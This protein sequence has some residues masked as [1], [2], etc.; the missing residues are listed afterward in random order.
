MANINLYNLYQKSSVW[1]FA[2]SHT[3]T[4]ELI[5]AVAT[6]QPGA[7]VT[8]P[9]TAKVIVQLPLRHGLYLNSTILV[10][11]TNPQPVFD[12]AVRGCHNVWYGRRIRIVVYKM[13]KKSLRMCLLVSMQYANVTDGRT[14]GQTNK[15]CTTA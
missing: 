2:F 5:P 12:A 10:C 13:V 1:C 7:L 6:A 3:S 4:F 14:D 8:T 9:K 11:C 15:Y